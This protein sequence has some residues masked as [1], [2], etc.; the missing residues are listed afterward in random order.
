MNQAERTYASI[1]LLPEALAARAAG[2]LRSFPHQG[3]LQTAARGRSPKS[4]LTLVAAGPC[5]HVAAAP[6]LARAVGIRRTRG[7]R[8]DRAGGGRGYV[9]K[10][11]DSAALVDAI[12]RV[13]QGDAYF[14]PRLAAFVLQAFSAPQPQGTAA[15]SSTS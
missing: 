9:T 5:L 7:R 14:S 15:Q 1:F 2:Y 10:T 6:E 4:K 12:G 8:A 11:I 3:R 13:Q